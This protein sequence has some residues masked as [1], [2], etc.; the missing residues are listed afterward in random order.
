MK[1]SPSTL[2]A[3][4]EARCKLDFPLKT[5][6]LSNVF[7]YDCVDDPFLKALDDDSSAS[8]LSL[9]VFFPCLLKFKKKTKQ[10]G[11]LLR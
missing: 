7:E 11:N 3:V 9:S 8:S 4:K 10:S 1:W 5:V 6:I 2:R